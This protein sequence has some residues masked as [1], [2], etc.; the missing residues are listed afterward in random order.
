MIHL[1]DDRVILLNHKFD[2][3]TVPLLY[4]NLVE[5]GQQLYVCFE[6]QNVELAV[7]LLE[8]PKNNWLIYYVS[9]SW[10]HFCWHIIF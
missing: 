3:T 6:T 1:A 2:E 8:I 4:L 7:V 9:W 10:F 5:D